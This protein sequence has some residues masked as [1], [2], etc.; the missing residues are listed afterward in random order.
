MNTP[1]NFRVGQEVVFGRPNGEKT[2]GRVVKVNP[3]SLKVQQ[4]EARG[5]R[6]SGLVWTVSP[7]FVKPTGQ[8]TSPPEAPKVATP[9][10]SDDEI[11]E[12]FRRVYCD[13]SPENLSCDGELAPSAVRAR[14]TVL[15]N[16]LKALAKELGRMVSEEE[17]LGFS[18]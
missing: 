14:A 5:G 10:R 18:Y 16:K 6:A 12:D 11:L 7:V 2:L 8:M 13:L 15:H 9:K 3:K 1:S 4:T 17:A